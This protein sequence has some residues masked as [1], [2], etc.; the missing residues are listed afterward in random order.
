VA[1]L[2]GYLRWAIPLRYLGDAYAPQGFRRERPGGLEVLVSPD[3]SFRIAIAAGNY[4]TGLDDR[5]P[6]TRIDRGPL[7]GQAVDFNRDQVRLDSNVIPFGPKELRP[8][9]VPAHLTWLLL[10]FYDEH[11]DE[12]RVELSVPIEF[13]RKAGTSHERGMV[14]RFEP[15]LIL[16]AISLAVV[17][18]FD[19]D[20]GDDQIDI[21]IDRRS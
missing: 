4:S 15:R 13:T 21:P 6:T 5:M 11:A 14:T 9:V 19:H 18:D 3:G 2:G 17:A 1:T 7:T 12:I 16:P 20:E 8:D 10:H